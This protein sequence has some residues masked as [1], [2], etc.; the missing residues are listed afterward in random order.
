LTIPSLATFSPLASR[1]SSSPRWPLNSLVILSYSPL[2]GPPFFPQLDCWLTL[3][4]NPWTS[5]LALSMGDFISDNIRCAAPALTF[6]WPPVLLTALL[7]S[8]LRYHKGISTL[9]W[10]IM[11]W[12]FF[13]ELLLFK[14]SP[15]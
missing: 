8:P 4:F 10:K 6:Q 7:V 1:I 3:V 15:C 14:A 11:T 5:S 9:L 12:F 13:L 2:L